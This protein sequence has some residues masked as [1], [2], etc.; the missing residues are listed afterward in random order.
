MFLLR[1][2]F[3]WQHGLFFKV[4]LSCNASIFVYMFVQKCIAT[5]LPP[6][7]IDKRAQLPHVIFH[8]MREHATHW[9]YRSNYLIVSIRPSGITVCPPSPYRIW[10][11]CWCSE[12][13]SH[14]FLQKKSVHI[15][16]NQYITLEIQCSWYI[17]DKN[18]SEA[19]PIFDLQECTK[20]C[21]GKCSLIE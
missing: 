6:M 14:G 8:E 11:L 7:L 5:L 10:L 16:N 1:W 9:C 15:I 4:A 18:H 19:H 13:V 17:I 12:P 20:T 3:A 21:F 2:D